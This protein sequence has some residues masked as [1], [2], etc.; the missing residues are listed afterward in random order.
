[1][2]VSII[3]SHFDDTVFL[4]FKQAVGFIDLAERVAVGDE[5]RGVDFAFLDETQNLF[6]IAAVDAASL[7]SEVFAV[8]V[9]QGQYLGFVV[10]RH[11]RDDGIGTCTLPGKAERVVASRHFQHAVG[12]AVVAVSGHEVGAFLRLREKNIGVVSLHK[13]AALFRLFADDNALRALQHSTE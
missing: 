8:H 9:G 12:A 1:M 4:V 10:E 7:E 13:G 2:L 6:A 3:D 5:R 11:D